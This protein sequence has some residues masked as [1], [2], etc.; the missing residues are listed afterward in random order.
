MILKHSDMLKD[1]CIHHSAAIM[2]RHKKL[3]ALQKMV[4]ELKNVMRAEKIEATTL[5]EKV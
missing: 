4:L 3:Q 2:K 5:A 1:K